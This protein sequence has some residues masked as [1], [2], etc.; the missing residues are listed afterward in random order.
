MRSLS[1]YA[2]KR[3]KNWQMLQV[4]SDIT[5][6]CQIIYKWRSNYFMSTKKLCIVK[7]SGHTPSTRDFTCITSRI[8]QHSF[9]LTKAVSL[10]NVAQGFHEVS[11]TWLGQTIFFPLQ[12]TS[13]VPSSYLEYLVLSPRSQLAQCCYSSF[14]LISSGSLS[15]L[16]S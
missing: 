7:S 14:N 4:V 16:W 11:K 3:Q 5:A 15:I 2:A 12:N 8:K 9:K 10:E 1:K 6:L 13:G